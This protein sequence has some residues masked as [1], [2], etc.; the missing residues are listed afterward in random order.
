[1][2]NKAIFLDR[3]GVI[4]NNEHHYYI[5]KPDQVEYVDGIFENLQFLA[6]MGFQ[7]FIVSNQGGISRGF[8]TKTDVENL[9]QELADTFRKHH[10]SITEMT[11]CPHHPEVEKCL[12]R[13][14]ESLLLEK[15]IA[16]YAIS[17][18]GSYLIG[19][20][21]TDMDAARNAGVCGIKVTP[22]RNMVESLSLIAE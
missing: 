8:Y 15:L 12:C 2:K 4:L 1:M 6:K 11:F 13:K 5:W 10:I 3:D 7:F 16:K 14:P 18:D 17:A 22:N 9:H 20:S 19:D 21:Q